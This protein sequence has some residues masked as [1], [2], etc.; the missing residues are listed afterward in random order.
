MD[1][2][3]ATGGGFEELCRLEPRLREL[4]E[5]VRAVRDDPTT[6]FF[7]SNFVWLPFNGRLRELLGV[8]R[9]PVDEEG[10]RE[11]LFDSR[12]YE[13][14]FVHL[15]RLLPPCRGCGCRRFQPVRE[16]QSQA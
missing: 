16:E 14:A 3:N 9:I 6:S 12:S 2:S 13:R 10:E 5:D 15:S 8:A 7:C 11:E 1:E 4:E